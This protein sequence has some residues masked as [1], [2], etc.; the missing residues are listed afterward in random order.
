[1]SALLQMNQADALEIQRRFKE[2][3]GT[4]LVTFRLIAPL[5]YKG[6]SF[7]K[8]TLGEG[9]KLAEEV[10]KYGQAHNLNIKSI[11]R[12][13]GT[14]AEKEIFLDTIIAEGGEGIVAHYS[15]G[16][17][18]TSDNRSR[19]SFIKLKRSVKST[20]LKEGIGDTY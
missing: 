15:K 2:G 18:N 13:I 17:Y 10:I 7:L 9:H 11:R 5:Y 4:D 8:R 6:I 16:S 20:M 1:M 19:T 3:Q 12:C 14:R